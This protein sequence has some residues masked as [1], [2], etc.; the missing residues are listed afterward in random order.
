MFLQDKKTTWEDVDMA[1]DWSMDK[2]LEIVLEEPD[3]FLKIKE[4]LTRIGIASKK[5][6][7]L[8]QSC[9]LLHKK[10]KYYIVHFK[11]MFYLDGKE[12]NLS[13]PDIKRR[14]LVA[15]LLK[16]WGLMKIVNPSMIEMKSS[17][18]TIRIVS[19]KDKTNWNLVS[20]YT[21]GS[22]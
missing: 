22:R 7:T 4:T 13:V 16:E 3:D 8:I 9:H 15:S 11:E 20:K 2:M 14:N 6:S 18:N 1:Y 12:T 5:E 10:G 19:H 17:L 21:I